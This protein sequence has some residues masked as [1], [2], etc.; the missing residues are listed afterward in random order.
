MPDSIG[1]SQMRESNDYWISTGP[2][3]PSVRCTVV[4]PAYGAEH[5]LMRA[6]ESALDQTLRDIEVIIV[7]DASPDAGW[8]LISGLLKK[9]K[10]VRAVR[11]KR[12][13]GKSVSMNLAL[14]EARGRWLAV[15][16]ADDW[17]HPD[18]LEVL[19][20]EG[21]RRHVE[22]VADNQF[23]Y[24]ARAEQLAGTAW[25]EGHACWT[26]SFDDFLLGSDAFENFNLGMLK[27]V[28]RTDFMRKV[29]LG[30]EARARHGEDFF[31]LLQFYLSGGSAAV[32]D[33]AYYYYT[34]PF[35]SISREWSHGDRTRYDFQ[36]SYEINRRYLQ[37]AGHVMTRRQRHR[38][39]ARNDGLKVLESYFSAKDAIA[40]KRW[41]SVP[42]ALARH[43]GSLLHLARRLRSR[44]LRDPKPSTIH[45][46]AS[47][48]RRRERA[49]NA[50]EPSHENN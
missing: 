50:L 5:T 39:L 24:D 13:R 17:Y 32:C 23:F 27:P 30:Y 46:I 20:A 36:N 38:L 1:D 7:D 41:L 10:R 26:L 6:A 12:N 40:E 37:E 47:R 25:P 29:G 9:D 21:E 45:H 14:S 8:D 48:A 43:P 3:M 15:L 33:A 16:D 34:Q 35:G 4:I 22:M 11:N 28:I 44:L 19:I 2:V 31:H 18:R 49:A 42:L